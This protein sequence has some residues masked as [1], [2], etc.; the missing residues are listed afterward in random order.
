MSTRSRWIAAVVLAVVLVGFGVQ[1]CTRNAL[2]DASADAPMAGSTHPP[3]VAPDAASAAV[4]AEA[5][6]AARAAHDA[7]M[8]AAVS[9]LHA[10]LAVLFKPDRSEADAYWVDGAPDARGE[11]DLRALDAVRSVRTENGR[12]VPMTGVSPPE[13]LEIPVRL[14]VATDAGVRQ[15][16]GYYRL[17]RV[18]A[19]N[20]WRITSA[21]ITASPS[22]N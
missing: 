11:A 22:R 10:Y 21:S 15:Y 4:E 12:P 17:R 7:A 9:E 16:T 2:D 1:R 20:R 6:R 3:A 5:A 13:S 18:V 8:S 19:G 14:R